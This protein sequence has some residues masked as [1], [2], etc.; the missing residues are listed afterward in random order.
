MAA[1]AESRGGP[2]PVASVC[3]ASPP[4]LHGK[5]LLQVTLQG[6]ELSCV[7][8][9][10]AD[11]Q[12]LHRFLRDNFPTAL[13]IPA[14]RD[15]VDGISAL[16]H[17]DRHALRREVQCRYTGGW[18]HWWLR[19]ERVSQQC[20][21]LWAM[22][23]ASPEDFSHLVAQGRRRGPSGFTSPPLAAQPAP[24]RSWLP[25]AL[26]GGAP[27]LPHHPVHPGREGEKQLIAAQQVLH[28]RLAAPLSAPSSAAARRA[29]ENFLEFVAALGELRG[30]QH[31]V[32]ADWGH[33]HSEWWLGRMGHP[34]P[35]A[36][37][38]GAAGRARGSS[39]RGRSC[40]SEVEQYDSPLPQDHSA[41]GLPRR[42]SV[43]CSAA[44]ALRGAGS[45]LCSDPPDPRKGHLLA[46]VALTGQAWEAAAESPPP[47]A[48]P[49][50]SLLF[51][52]GLRGAAGQLHEQCRAQAR[53]VAEQALEAEETEAGHPSAVAA[54]AA[55]IATMER[56]GAEDQR[57]GYRMSRFLLGDAARRFAQ[58]GAEAAAA[59][60][61]CWQA[62]LDALDS[63]AD[64]DY[65]ALPDAAMPLPDDKPWAR[66]AAE[67][68]RLA[69]AALCQPVV[70]PGEVREL[71][72]YGFAAQQRAAGWRL[73]L[74]PEK[75]L[76]RRV[77]DW[78]EAAELRRREYEGLRHAVFGR[79]RQG[80]VR[81]GAAVRAAPAAD[82]EQLSQFAEEAE[83]SFDQDP[84]AQRAGWEKLA[85]RDGW[86]CAA[87]C[88]AAPASETL[89][90]IDADI[91]RTLPAEAFWHL[92]HAGESAEG[93]AACAGEPAR[94]ELPGSPRLR[95]NH[96]RLRRVLLVYAGLNPGLGY[97]QGMNEIA[98]HL[99]MCLSDD[100]ATDSSLLEADTFFCFSALL[101]HLGNNFCRALDGDASGLRGTMEAFTRCLAA[102]DLPTAQKLEE[103]GL[104]PEYYAMRWL[105]LMFSQEFRDRSKVLR[106][107]D[108]LLSQIDTLQQ[109]LVHVA[110]A[111]VV[112]LRERL[113]AGDFAANIMLLQ[114]YPQD[115][116]ME[117]VVRR[118]AEVGLRAEAAA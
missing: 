50:A 87:D 109:A 73:I 34:F 104:R 17:R 47:P 94:D 83:A 66:P 54:A 20:G 77:A 15:Q 95:R 10:S 33:L 100:P 28:Q 107:W 89:T 32:G 91:P 36:R 67:R 53:R 31:E 41:G 4:A 27:Q 51:A 14:P 11:I 113:L 101:T 23:N 112:A 43:G 37:A 84:A 97:V 68:H 12:W 90:R 13:P 108:Y 74:L 76:P 24:D 98:A 56:E 26:G 6:G 52:A 48:A 103:Q 61:A 40:P 57:E 69:D 80:K 93:G 79:P 9:A 116:D 63:V 117:S 45:H 111:L 60:E 64:V 110:T 72:M 18:L 106:V 58:A 25:A 102:C 38:P 92:A 16:R 3:V 2:R 99:M 114:E 71:A 105:T 59:E 78:P 62:V 29:G 55:A 7:Q 96:H 118:A 19:H 65:L 46:L 86:V 22:A 44:A 75:L 30:A 115:V 81:A 82:A 88:S 42:K 21:E 49:A 85:G 5:Y 35:L 39:M 8:R 1:P 70:N